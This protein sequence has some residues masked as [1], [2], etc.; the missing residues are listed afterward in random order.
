[1]TKSCKIIPEGVVLLISEAGFVTEVLHDTFNLFS[2]ES[3]SEESFISCLKSDSLKKGCRFIE[4]INN[5]G[6][7]YNWELFIEKK[8]YSSLFNFSGVKTEKGI[9]LIGS[10]DPGNFEQFLNGLMEMNNEQINKLRLFMKKH[11]KELLQEYEWKM[12]D[13]L[14]QLNNELANTQREL[15]KKT[16]ELE[17]INKLKNQMMG[18]AAHD[19]RNPLMLIQNYAFFLMDEHQEAAF[20][21]EDQY[22]LVKQIKG[23]SEYM[24][25]IIEDMLDI[26]A[27]E[28][29]IINL[30]KKNYNLVDLIEDVVSLNRTSANKKNIVITTHLPDS[31]VNKVID[32]HKFRQVLDNLMSNA[33]KY[34]NPDTGV[35]VG[36]RLADASGGVAIYVKDHGQGIPKG[37][38]GNL[39]EPF[40]QT[41]VRS[42]AGE[43][44]T[45]LGLAI[46][47]KIVEAH[48]GKIEVESEVGVGSTFVVKIP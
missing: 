37:E 34:S 6:V 39:F 36:I 10:P 18:M 30:K 29:G 13:D 25:Q 11:Q 3:G 7:A 32:G 46:V 38:I 22:Q 47:K 15:T 1:M 41:S 44:S 9:L 28:S 43:K 24:V 31:S 20:L 12:Y 26:A 35:E 23:S 17:R 14:S 4:S 16:T 2:N 45:G 40:L 8:D 27:F 21:T 42:T 33:V 19:L 48:G 5:N